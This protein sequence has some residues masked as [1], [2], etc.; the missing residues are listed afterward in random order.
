MAIFITFEGGEGCGKSTQA[1]ALY[2][3]VSRKGLPV[4]LSQEPGGTP[5]GKE[6]RRHL[7]RTEGTEISPL[8]ELFLFAASRA[9]LVEKVIIPSLESG[10]IVICDRY[11]DSTTAYQG[12]GRGLDLDTVQTINTTAT[13][14]ISPD[15][16]ILLDLPVEIG[17]SRKGAI[18]GAR[19]ERE[20]IAFHQRVRNGFLRM[21][22]TDPERWLVIDAGVSRSEVSRIIRDKVGELIQQRGSR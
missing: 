12:Y 5:L 4:V 18:K 2:K 13:G 20:E 22:K 19:F 15:L 6:L 7:K 11:S 8:A 9:Q 17:L 21:A 16:V 14:G 1:R 3:H 10:A